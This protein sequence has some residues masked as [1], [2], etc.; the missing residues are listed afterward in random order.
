MPGSFFD[1]NVLVYFASDEAA[2]ADRAEELLLGGGTISVQV[3]NELALVCRRRFAFSW[4]EV[5]E[6]LHR[7]R[8][9]VEVRPLD[10]EIHDTGLEIAESYQLSIYDSFL[11]AAALS[12][13][14]DV[15][16]SE[17]LQ[18]GLTVEGRLTVQNP[19]R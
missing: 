11:L 4:E 6:T 9:A 12:A 15:F 8:A 16:W 13:D 2:K 19:F 17:D 5:H 14:C 7:I 18:H 1:T 10:L 3:L